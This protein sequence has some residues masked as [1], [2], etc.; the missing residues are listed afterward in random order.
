M[1]LLMECCFVPFGDGVSIGARYVQ[2]L[3]QMYHMVRN[4]FGHHQMYS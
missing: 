4:H 2:D 3:H 1:E